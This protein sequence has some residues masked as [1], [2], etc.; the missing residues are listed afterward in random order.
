MNLVDKILSGRN[1][2]ESLLA[3]VKQFSKKTFSSKKTFTEGEFKDQ[4]IANK[5]IY[6][7]A[8]D[9]LLDLLAFAHKEYPDDLEIAFDEGG[10]GIVCHSGGNLVLQYNYN[11]K[12]GWVHSHATLKTIGGT[13]TSPSDDQSTEPPVSDQSSTEEPE[14]TED[15]DE[16]V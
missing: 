5:T 13:M 6:A 4:V 14:G 15:S 10:T 7:I 11:E 16:E 9:G 3:D 12:Y 2:R 1:I 8:G